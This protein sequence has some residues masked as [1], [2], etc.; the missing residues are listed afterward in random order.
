MRLLRVAVLA[1]LLSGALQASVTAPPK[2][3]P[4]GWPTESYAVLVERCQRADHA[5]FEFGARKIFI[6]ERAWLDALDA[7]LVTDQ[8]KPDARCFC[9]SDYVLKLYSKNQFLCSVALTHD[10][11]VR[12]T[13]GDYIVPPETHATLRKLWAVATKAESYAPPKRSAQHS[14]PPRVELKP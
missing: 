14:A 12:F 9:V 7:A 2:P 5:V 8:A 6:T 10:N 11:K 1:A 3:P 13:G 4:P